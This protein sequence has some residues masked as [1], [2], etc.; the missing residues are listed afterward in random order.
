MAWILR[1]LHGPRNPT[2]TLITRMRATPTFYFAGQ[3]YRVQV[4]EW[5][6]G[7]PLVTLHFMSASEN[8]CWMVRRQVLMSIA[9]FE[10]RWPLQADCGESHIGVCCHNSEICILYGFVQSC[11]HATH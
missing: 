10:Q 2:E 9:T 11:Y 7:F 1:L 4:V 6:L 3:T 8:L 5:T